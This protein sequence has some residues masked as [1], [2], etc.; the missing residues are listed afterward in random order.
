MTGFGAALPV[1]GLAIAFQDVWGYNRDSYAN[2]AAVIAGRPSGSLTTRSYRC[3]SSYQARV[4]S[5]VKGE[6]VNDV[7]SL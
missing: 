2:A 4:R 7:H 1:V 6:E 3:G 5:Q